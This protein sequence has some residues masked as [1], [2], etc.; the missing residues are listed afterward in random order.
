MTSKNNISLAIED[1]FD[2]INSK[3]FKK[4]SKENPPGFLA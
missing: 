1:Y 4:F 3:D 2:L